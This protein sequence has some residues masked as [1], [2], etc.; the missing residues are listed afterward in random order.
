[1]PIIYLAGGF[2]S[3]W[4]NAVH[5]A[6]PSWEVLDPSQHNLAEPSL[7][8]LWD[9]EAIRQS[10]YVLA[11]MERTNPAGYAL[12]L[13]VGYAKALAKTILLVEEHD[14]EG[15]RKYFEMVR[16]VSDHQFDTLEAAIRYLQETDRGVA[17]TL[18]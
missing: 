16:Q 18:G 12:A 13:E 1:V 9:L 11:Y 3:G 10:S 7:Y 17:R 6:L 2:R 15:R 4:Q 8:T 5:K 14:T